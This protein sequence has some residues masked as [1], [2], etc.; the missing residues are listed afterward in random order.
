[1]SKQMY[2]VFGNALPSS[3]TGLSPTFILYNWNGITAIPGPTI[4]ETTAGSGI[5]GF[6]YGGTQSIAWVIDGGA[7]LTTNSIRYL[8]GSLDPVMVM[9]QSIGFSTDSVGSTLTDPTTLYGQI[10]RNQEFNEGDK[11]FTKSTGYWDV[12]ARGGTLLL[13]EKALSNTL[14]NATSTES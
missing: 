3:Y 6:Q 7:T 1:M 5:Y 4:I 13:F 8:S 11:T 2:F 14:T 12:Y 10:K 9:D